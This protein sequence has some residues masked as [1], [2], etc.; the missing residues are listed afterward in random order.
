MTDV[1]PA[2]NIETKAYA[3]HFSIR[4]LTFISDAC[5]AERPAKITRLSVLLSASK[6]AKIY[7]GEYAATDLRISSRASSALPQ[8]PIF[9]HFPGSSVL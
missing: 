1:N 4:V 6:L 8:R 7:P 5:S 9:T 2:K 3:I